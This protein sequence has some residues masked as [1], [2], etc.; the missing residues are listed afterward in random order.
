MSPAALIWKPPSVAGTD[1][2]PGPRVWPSAWR[3]NACS[4]TSMQLRRGSRSNTSAPDSTR[5]DVARWETISALLSALLRARGVEPLEQGHSLGKYLVIITGRR[6]QGPDGHIDAPRFLVGILAVTK[7]CLVHHL[8]EASEPAIPETGSLHERL[9]RAVLSLV[10]ELYPGRVVG[11]GVLRKLRGGREDKDRFRIDEPLDQ[12]GRRHP[13]HVRPWSRDPPPPPQLA[14]VEALLRFWLRVFRTSGTHGDGPLETSAL[15]AAGSV[16]EVDV[17]DSLIVLRETDELLVGLP[18]HRLPVEAL[19]H[20][21]VARAELTVVTVARLVEQPQ[22]VPG[23]HVL[24]LL[25]SNQ[26]RLA[27]LSLDFLRQPL[28]V[29]VAFGSVRQQIGRAFQ[30]HRPEGSKPSPDP[31]PKARRRRRQPDQ[32]K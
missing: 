2:T 4:T 20:P 30:R 28:K 21:A 24:D 25:H 12:P 15:G 16:E 5:I 18:A 6:E 26:C 29:L 3:R 10:T 7:V 23:T 13:I 31:H 9:E 1:R 22:H 11:D 32:E 8:R 27:A 17:A 14:Q 19:Q